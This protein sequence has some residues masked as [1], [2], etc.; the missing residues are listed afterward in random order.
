MF[1]GDCFDWCEFVYVWIVDEYVE[2]VICFDC[3]ID[4]VLCVGGFWYVVVDCDCVVVC[5]GDCVDDCVC[6]CF[7]VCVVDDDCCVFVG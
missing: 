1:F 2:M 5:F 6:V 3:C 4:D 7:V